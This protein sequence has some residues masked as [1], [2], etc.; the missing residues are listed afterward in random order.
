MNTSDIIKEFNEY[1]D[2]AYRILQSSTN[3]IRSKQIISDIFKIYRCNRFETIIFRLTIIDSYYSTQMNKRFFGLDDLANRLTEVANNDETLQSMCLEFISNTI[4]NNGIKDLFNGKYGIRKTGQNVGQAAS[5]ISK[6][7][8]FLTEYK[9]PIYDNLVKISYLLVKNKYPQ[10]SIPDINKKFDNSYFEKIKQL[11]IVTKTYDYN[12][13]DNLLWLIGKLTK[14]SLSVILNKDRYL[15][16][17]DKIK[18]P[19]GTNS[20][21]SDTL[22]RNYI[23]QNIDTLRDLFNKDEIKFLKYSHYLTVANSENRKNRNLEHSS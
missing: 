11:N 3:Y 6:Y 8:Y 4:I 9:F 10:L 19:N 14:G 18:I 23:K 7:L 1:T 17:I 20:K 15:Q 5:L 16:L 21:A 12:K 2:I 13:L 22:I